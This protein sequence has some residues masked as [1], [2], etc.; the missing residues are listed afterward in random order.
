MCILGTGK[1]C[2]IHTQY[3]IHWMGNGHCT[4]YGQWATGHVREIPVD[5][6]RPFHWTLQPML[7]N[8]FCNNKL[9]IIRVN[10]NAI[11][12]LKAFHVDRKQNF[13]WLVNATNRIGGGI[14][15]TIKT[16][17]SKDKTWFELFLALNP[18]VQCLPPICWQ[19]C[20]PFGAH[21]QRLL[22]QIKQ[23]FPQ[24]FVVFEQQPSADQA[25]LCSCCLISRRGETV[26]AQ[27]WQTNEHVYTKIVGLGWIKGQKLP[28]L[29]IIS[30]YYMTRCGIA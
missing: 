15:L 14:T 7:T 20:W 12:F 9:I 1:F 4:I 29:L 19:W 17:K 22:Q 5:G 27:S 18:Q 25:D 11:W 2:A 13:I 3:T 28:Y 8:V 24:Y 30:R 21:F 6:L 23:I 16:R 10:S 26:W